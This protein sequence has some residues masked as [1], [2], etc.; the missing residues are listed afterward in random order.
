[1]SKVTVFIRYCLATTLNHRRRLNASPKPYGCSRT[2]EALSSFKQFQCLLQESVH[3]V[4]KRT[5]LVVP[6]QRLELD[7]RPSTAGQPVGLH[8]SQLEDA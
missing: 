1:V 7:L 3:H 4:S 8:G 2:A 6:L 5:P